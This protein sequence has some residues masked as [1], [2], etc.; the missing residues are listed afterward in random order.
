MGNKVC[1][2]WLYFPVSQADPLERLHEVQKRMNELKRLPVAPIQYM[3]LRV[4]SKLTIRP[5][6]Q[7]D[8]I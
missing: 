2:V 1:T 3:N 8:G 5:M 7:D 6:N 4:R